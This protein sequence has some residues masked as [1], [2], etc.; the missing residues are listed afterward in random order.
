MSVCEAI[1]GPLTDALVGNLL[2]PERPSFR[3]HSTLKHRKAEIRKPE[4]NAKNRD[5]AHNSLLPSGYQ[6]PK[7]EEFKR[8]LEHHHGPDIED[9]CHNDELRCENQLSGVANE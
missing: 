7:K 6:K 8:Q 9:F 5:S 4:D 3:W 1:D 2:V